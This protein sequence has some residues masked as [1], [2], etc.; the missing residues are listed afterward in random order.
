MSVNRN[1]E[2]SLA[3]PTA[4]SFNPSR[5][6]PPF[7]NF[8]GGA[9]Y[10]SGLAF[11]HRGRDGLG[12]QP[13]L[14]FGQQGPCLFPRLFVGGEV[15]Q[16]E[17]D[18]LYRGVF[19]SILCQ[20]GGDAGEAL[21]RHR[22]IGSPQSVSQG[23][24]EVVFGCVVILSRASHITQPNKGVGDESRV[25]GLR[26]DGKGLFMQDDG[27]FVFTEP[28]SGAGRVVEAAGQAPSIADLPKNL[29][30]L[31][32][33]PTGLLVFGQRDGHIAQL[34]E[35]EGYCRSLPYASSDGKAFLIQA[36]RILVGSLGEAD[37]A[38]VVL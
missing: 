29:R 7:D 13:G 4:A 17:G 22:G 5:V 38:Q 12:F 16:D 19:L 3:R 8:P 32:V 21:D 14:D 6:R 25:T 28:V 11:F 31:L 1:T 23:L 24:P 18:K 36:S 26:V 9:Q 15:V 35:G 20:D 33:E 34:A 30:A 27:L 10:V 2:T 37:H